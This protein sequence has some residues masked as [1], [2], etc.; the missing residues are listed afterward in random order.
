[1]KFLAAAFALAATVYF[2]PKTGE[3][4][5]Q[6]QQLTASVY[7]CIAMTGSKASSNALIIIAENQAI[8]AG[9]HFTAEGVKELQAEISRLTPLPLRYVILTHH[10]RG[11]NYLDLDLPRGVELVTS[12]QAWQALKSEYREKRNSVT[13]FDKGLTMVRGDTT[14]VLSNTEGGHSEGDVILFLPQEG[15]LFTSDLVFNDNAGYMGDGHMREWVIN[16][17]TLLALSP[18]IVVPGVGNVTDSGGIVRFRDFLRDFLTEVLRH[19]EKGESL[20]QTMKGFSLPQHEKLPGYRIFLNVNI[21]R[22]YKE[23]K[24]N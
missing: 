20:A 3:A 21:E 10:H 24:K 15:I 17:E 22:A 6:I 4:N 2:P 23:L 5:Y 19:L 7:A 13:F 1:M 11:Y 18:R 12:W 14:I 9:A 8:L 16:L